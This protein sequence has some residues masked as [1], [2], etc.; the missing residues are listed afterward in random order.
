M[1]G[2]LFKMFYTVTRSLH[3][4]HAHTELNAIGN[5]FRTAGQIGSWRTYCSRT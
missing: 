4:V 3:A 2:I 1:H 5:L